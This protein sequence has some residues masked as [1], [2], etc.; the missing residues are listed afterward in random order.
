MLVFYSMI[1]LTLDLLQCC[2][3]FKSWSVTQCSALCVK[4]PRLFVDGRYIGGEAEIQRLHESGE[5]TDILQE[6]G[7]L[8]FSARVLDAYE[9]CS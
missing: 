5:L 1:R 9:W 6:A 3:L 4:V 7:A 2:R 8:P